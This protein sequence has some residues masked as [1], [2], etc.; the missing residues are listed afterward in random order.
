MMAAKRS[1]RY[2]PPMAA[3]VDLLSMAAA[4]LRRAQSLNT[5]SANPLAR[6][7]VENVVLQVIDAHA[8][9]RQKPHMPRQEQETLRALLERQSAKLDA[10]EPG[11]AQRRS[12]DDTDDQ[13]SE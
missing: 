3:H 9:L 1:W 11:L 2:H 4:L 6:R 13:V 8:A 7:S 5:S 12:S 10:I